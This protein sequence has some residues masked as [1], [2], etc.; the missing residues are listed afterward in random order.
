MYMYRKH[1]SQ[2]LGIDFFTAIK[3]MLCHKIWE[4]IG[5]EC[6][7]N[8]MFNILQLLNTKQQAVFSCMLWSIWKQR[9]DLIWQNEH[10]LWVAVCE[11]VRNLLISWKNAHESKGMTLV[12]QQP[13]HVRWSKPQLGC[14]KCNADASCDRARNMVGIGMC[15]R[16]PSGSHR[17]SMLMKDKLQDCYMHLNGL[18]SCPSIM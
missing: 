7:S 15:I 18:K 11:R 16:N 12:Q 9:N 14:I 5:M 10:L 4:L 6:I 2:D 13:S 17:C 3:I 1:L 8:I